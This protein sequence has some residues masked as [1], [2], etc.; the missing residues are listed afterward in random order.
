MRPGADRRPEPTDLGGRV[1]SPLRGLRWGLLLAVVA[2]LVL[3]AVVLV[4]EDGRSGSGTPAAVPPLSTGPNAAAT[5]PATTAPGTTAPGTTAAASTAAPDAA[6]A[7]VTRGALATGWEFEGW[8][9]D[10]AVRAGPGGPGG[11][12]AVEVTYRKPWGGFALRQGSAAGPAPDAVLRVRVYVTGPPV[13]LGLQVQSAD[14]G[15]TGAVVQRPA[16][17][18]QWVTLAAPLSELRPPA[19]VRRVSVIAQDVPPGTTIWVSDVTLR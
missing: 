12:P 13:R 1:G 7:I 15:G 5:T 8:S 16:P 18:R 2:A 14:D 19:G 11:T 9:W 6:G 17:S 10:S 4:V 3:F